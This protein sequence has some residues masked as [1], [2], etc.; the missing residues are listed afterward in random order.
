MRQSVLNDLAEVDRPLA[1]FFRGLAPWMVRPFNT[2]GR[3][4]LP[5]TDVFARNGDIIVKVELPGI[6]AQKDVTVT[7][8]DGELTIKGERREDKEVKEDGY[9][10]KESTFG[11][12]ER[13]VAVPDDAK[14]GEIKA[15]YHDGVLEVVIPKAASPVAKPKAKAIPVTTGKPAKA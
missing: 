5:T 12:F 2:A 10:R 1:D 3:P 15:T 6:D 9:Y 8:E 14:G 7:Y 11:Y 4:Y 13:H